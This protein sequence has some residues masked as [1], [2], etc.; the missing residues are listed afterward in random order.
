MSS[1]NNISGVGF[2]P[3]L[4]RTAKS[5]PFVAKADESKISKSSKPNFETAY[6]MSSR[7]TK[8]TL[9]MISRLKDK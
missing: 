7:P 4:Q 1:I 9:E 8:L 2:S 3:W 6:L 5:E